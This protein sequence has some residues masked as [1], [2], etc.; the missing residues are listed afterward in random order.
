V[1]AGTIRN[2]V[3]SVVLLSSGLDSAVNLKCAL[4]RGPV[5]AAL[6]FDYGHRAA[7]REAA[8]AAAMCERF[9]VAHEVVRLPW[10]GRITRTALVDARRTLPHP[11]AADLDDPRAARRSAERVWAPNRNGVFLAV[12]AAFAES[13]GADQVVPGFNAEEAATFPDNS[14][15]FV[16]AYNRAL[17]LSTLSRV[18]VRSYTARRRKPAIVRLGIEIGAPLDLAWCCYEGGRRLCGRCESCRRFLRAIA[19]ARAEEW[20]RQNHRWMPEGRE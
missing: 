16:T 5:P 10:L 7:K 20:F 11:R 3:T 2:R 17:R 9:D 12:A 4:D 14:P 1:T 8:R 15:E 6:T 19:E 18:K 13:L